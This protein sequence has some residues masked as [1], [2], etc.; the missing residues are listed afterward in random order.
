M[1]KYTCESITKELLIFIKEY[2]FEKVVQTVLKENLDE[3]NKVDSYIKELKD[4]LSKEQCY[5]TTLLVVLLYLYFQ[6]EEIKEKSPKV[7]SPLTSKKNDTSIDNTI[8]NIC[9]KSAMKLFDDST[10]YYKSLYL[11]I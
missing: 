5:L 8:D 9:N 11:I 7:P 4:C 2:G 6:I 10:V 1:E 3:K